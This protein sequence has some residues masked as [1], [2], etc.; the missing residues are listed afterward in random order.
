MSES[1][2]EPSFME[3]QPHVIL[4]VFMAMVIILVVG[5]VV[6][7]AMSPYKKA[8]E[9]DSSIKTTQPPARCVPVSHRPV[10]EFL[11]RSADG[12]FRRCNSKGSCFL[13]AVPTAPYKSAR[14]VIS[15]PAVGKLS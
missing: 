15:D 13:L 4:V 14:A 9:D 6:W 10:G 3:K 8:V 2:L 7:L 5:A 12:Q 11:C 1:R